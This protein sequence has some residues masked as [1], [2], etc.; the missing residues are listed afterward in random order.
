MSNIV[1]GD[2]GTELAIVIFDDSGVVELSSVSSITA[3]IERGDKS[4][5]NKNFTVLDEEEGTCFT[6]LTGEDVSVPGAYT[7]RVKVTFNDE[8]EFSSNKYTFWVDKK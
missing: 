2:K 3:S 1:Q 8:S 7:F 4:T 6:A 5:I